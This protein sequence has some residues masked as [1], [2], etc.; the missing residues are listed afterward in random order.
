MSIIAVGRCKCGHVKSIHKNILSKSK[1]PRKPKACNF[2]GCS[3]KEYA[4]PR[5]SA[6]R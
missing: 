2:P 4:P 3:C 5:R 1:E 6:K